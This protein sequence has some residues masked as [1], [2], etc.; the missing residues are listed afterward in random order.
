MPSKSDKHSKISTQTHFAV[1]LSH[2]VDLNFLRQYISINLKRL[3]ENWIIFDDNLFTCMYF[4]LAFIV[5]SF[6]YSMVVLPLFKEPM[7]IKSIQTMSQKS[8]IK[9]DADWNCQN[10][11]CH[12][13][14]TWRDIL[15][16]NFN[17]KTSSRK[18]FDQFISFIKWVN[19]FG[20]I[21]STIHRSI[22]M[23]KM[24]RQSVWNEQTFDYSSNSVQFCLP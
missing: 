1:S 23:L 18:I 4:Y 3:F 21:D 17:R 24:S 8:L 5:F 16:D 7:I 2:S 14:Y 6:V 20:Y 9:I 15:L 10:G 19:L 11:Q 22:S 13:K 12:T